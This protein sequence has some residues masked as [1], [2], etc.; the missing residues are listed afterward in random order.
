M[1]GSDDRATAPRGG[2]GDAAAAGADLRGILGSIGETVYDWDLTDDRLTWGSQA[3]AILRAASPESLASGRAFARLVVPGDGRSRYDT[4]TGSPERDAGHGVPFQTV[5]ALKTADGDLIRVEDTGR[6]FG[7][8]DGRPIKVHG[9]LRVLSASAQASGSS[10]GGAVDPLTGSLTRGQLAEM[11]GDEIARARKSHGCFAMLLVG[12]EGLGEINE[13]YGFDVADELI[14]GVAQRLRSVM[15]RADAMARFAGNKIAIVLTGCTEDQLPVAASRFIGALREGPVQTSAG[16]LAASVRAGGVLLPRFGHTTQD[17]MQHADEALAAARASVSEAFIAYSPDR[18]RDSRRA[19]NRR[20][21]DEVIAALNEQRI[22]I[23]RQPIVTAKTRTLAMREALMR[24]TRTDGTVMSAASVIPTVEKLG[25]MPMLDQRVLDLALADLQADPQARL[26]INVSPSSLRSPD[27]IAALRSRLATRP[28]LAARLVVEMTETCLVDDIEAMRERLLTMKG[29][30]L[31]LA[32]DDFGSGHTSFRHLRDMPFDIVKI[33][34]AFVQN[35]GRST[36]DRFFVRTL[37]DLA[38]HLGVEVVA[39]WVVD[40]AS[41][42]MLA[43]W[44]VD[45]L[46]GELFDDRAARPALPRAVA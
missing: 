32:I 30:G 34:G 31:R 13:A 39:E 16:A 25:F 14:A 15:R 22:A 5:Y 38:R 9:V 12:I 18:R 17:A 33:D 11:L 27:W 21:T 45:Y 37:L 6:W 44:G 20:F 8:L 1:R 23:A 7:G 28:D 40:E 35:I 3:V 26:A 43:D 2:G 19:G 36:D 42:Q 4:V 46:Q 41:A 29:L 24:I 10:S